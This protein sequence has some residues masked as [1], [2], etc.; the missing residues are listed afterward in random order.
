VARPELPSFDLVVATVGR[1]AEL[2]RFLDSL[3]AQTHGRFR[4][5]LV[6]QNEDARLD[7]V[8]AVRSSMDVVH[9]RSDRGLSR[10]RNRALGEVSGDLVAF[11]DDD[12][13]YAPDLLERVALRFREEPALDGLTG[14]AVGPDGLSSASW[15]KGAARLTSRNLWNRAISY[16]IFLRREVV[17][18]VGTFDEQLGLGSGN[19]WS[20]GEE[21][22]FLVRVLH[23]GARISYEPALTVTHDRKVESSSELRDR[24]CRDGASIGYILRKHRYPARVVAQRLTRPVGGILISVMRLDLP[25]ARFH[26]ATLRGRIAGM[27]GARETR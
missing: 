26:A 25:Q 7:G 3:A 22:D 9:L 1:V 15:K 6:D 24:G 16:T 11:P 5:L 14:R 21:I 8:V 18:K 12:C 20:S 13:V 27:K 23:A 17:E 4:V 19:P 10:A 2:E